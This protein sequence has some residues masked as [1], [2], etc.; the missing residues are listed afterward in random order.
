MTKQK[1]VLA[2]DHAGFRL[3][4]ELLFEV[5][6]LGY[7][8]EDLGTDRTDAVDYPDYGH[9]AARA[10]LSSRVDF[11]VICCGTGIGMAMAANKHPGI[12]AAVCHNV[13]TARFARAHNDANI[14]AI[15]ERVV[16]CELAK[17]C[18]RT[19][20]TTPFDGGR[21]NSRVNKIDMFDE[22]RK[23]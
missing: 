11:A 3:K 13:A 6:S 18:V 14:L 8:V 2:A 9:A 16:E 20:L 22:E 17:E 19:F 5:E 1:I 10:V 4:A 15:G 12:R 23:T 7:E 21:H